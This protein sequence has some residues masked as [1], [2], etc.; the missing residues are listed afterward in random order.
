MLNS[1]TQELKKEDTGPSINVELANVVDA[2]V[3]E[4]LPEEKLQENLNKQVKELTKVNC[5][6]KKVSTHSGRSTAKPGHHRHNFYAHA[7]GRP[8]HQQFTGSLLWFLPQ[9]SSDLQEVEEGAVKVTQISHIVDVEVRN[10]SEQSVDIIGGQLK[11]FASRC[12]CT[13]SD[14]FILNSVKHYKIDF[15]N[16]EP[17]QCMPLK[18]VNFTQQDRRSLK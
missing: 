14:S 8:G 9:T 13:T 17:Q 16:G 1:L 11:Q 12:Q 3:E 4:G 2:M 5:I 18:E 6:G 7:H 10:M 15:E